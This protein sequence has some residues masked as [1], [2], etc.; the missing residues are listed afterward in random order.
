MNRIPSLSTVQIVLLAAVL[1]SALF[2][3]PAAAAFPPCDSTCPNSG[4]STSCTCIHAQF[5]VQIHTTCGQMHNDCSCGFFA[6]ENSPFAFETT[7]AV[8][9][10][11]GTDPVENL[12]P[13]TQAGTPEDATEPEEV[14]AEENAE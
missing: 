13:A 11:A 7:L 12:T 9:F 10:E 8:L 6:P 4:P 5:G 14:Q 1:F 2:A 3:L